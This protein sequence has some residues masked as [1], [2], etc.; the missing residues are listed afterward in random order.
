MNVVRLLRKMSFRFEIQSKNKSN[1]F[2]VIHQITFFRHSHRQTILTFDIA[3]SARRTTRGDDGGDIDVVA[4]VVIVV[5]DVDV[6]VNAFD[7][8]AGGGT[9]VGGENAT[10]LLL[11]TIAPRDALLLTPPAPPPILLLLLLRDGTT[12]GS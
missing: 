7:G 2:C 8:G 1:Y 5:V 4:V 10:A 6:D 3:A 9:R 12:G 11:L